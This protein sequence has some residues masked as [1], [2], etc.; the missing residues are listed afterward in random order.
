M[1]CFDLPE[2][3]ENRMGASDHD[4]FACK[5]LAILPS[6]FAL[7]I[8]AEGLSKWKRRKPRGAKLI[9]ESSKMA[10]MHLSQPSAFLL[11]GRL[12]SPV[13]LYPYLDIFNT[14]CFQASPQE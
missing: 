13:S 4:P 5:A 9:H 7:A 6:I 12:N 11:C 1:V 14:K 8:A 2:I 3:L 10:R